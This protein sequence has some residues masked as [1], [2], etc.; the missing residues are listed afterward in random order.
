S[1]AF[2]SNHIPVRFSRGR[3]TFLCQRS[4]LLA[5]GVRFEPK[6]A[7]AC[8]ERTQSSTVRT[9]HQAGGTVGKSF[10]IDG[11]PF[12]RKC[13]I[14]CFARVF[15]FFRRFALLRRFG[16]FVFWDGLQFGFFSTHTCWL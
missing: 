1:I 15:L 11:N 12:S 14:G 2:S 10:E 8:G 16:P 7:L 4:L 5:S 13:T 6:D 9:F 3:P